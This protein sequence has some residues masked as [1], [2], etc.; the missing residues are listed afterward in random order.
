MNVGE[1]NS[2]PVLNKHDPDP[3]TAGRPMEDIMYT[4]KKNL[5]LKT[6][7]FVGMLAIILAAGTAMAQMPGGRGQGCDDK[8]P[9]A[10]L[11]RMAKHLDL[12]AD[13]QEVIAK[14][15]QDNREQMVELRKDLMRLRNERQGEMLKDDPSQKTVLALTEQM[16]EVKTKLQLQRMETRLA[17]RNQLTPEQQDKMM[18]MKD[19]KKGGRGKPG[20]R[21]QACGQGGNKCGNQCG[22]HKG[23]RSCR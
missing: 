3:V 17:V 5:I 16:G 21:G 9:E 8:G 4:Q 23:Q 14:I 11:E 22:G 20:K 13:Q 6:G 2:D 12:T 15:H 7:L 10:R 19:G 1:T 18:M